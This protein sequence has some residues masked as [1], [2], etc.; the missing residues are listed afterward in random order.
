MFLGVWYLGRD[1]SLFVAWEVEGG[2]GIQ[3]GSRKRFQE[4]R[5]DKP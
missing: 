1:R 2:G 4:S 5:G 3:G